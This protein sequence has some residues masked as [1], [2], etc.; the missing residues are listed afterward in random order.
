MILDLIKRFV[1][2]E[3][4]EENWKFVGKETLYDDDWKEEFEVNVYKNISFPERLRRGLCILGVSAVVISFG[5]II[6]DGIKTK[7]ESRK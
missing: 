5:I 3:E 4:Y 1:Y 7:I 2:S 6:V